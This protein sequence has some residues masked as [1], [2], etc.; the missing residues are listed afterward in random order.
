MTVPLL[1]W[2][3]PAPPTLESACIVCV[4]P[5]N[6]SVV[7]ELTLK[8][9][10]LD[11]PPFK[12]SVPARTFTAPSLFSATLIG[13]TPV[14]EDFLNVPALFIAQAVPPSQ[15]RVLSVW[16]SKVA[17]DWLETMAPEVSAK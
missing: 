3:V 6:C 10:P 16:M 4:P 7:P 5:L 8:E 2:K 15:K 14:P 12:E 11:P 9:P 17:P 13:E 1:T